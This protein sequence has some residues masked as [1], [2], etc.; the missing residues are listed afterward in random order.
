VTGGDN[1]RHLPLGFELIFACY[2]SF[3][4]VFLEE[5]RPY[6][7]SLH[8]RYLYFWHPHAASLG[9]T[10]FEL[11]YAGLFLIPAF[12][13]F[14]CLRLTRRFPVTRLLLP[15][16]GLVAVAGFPLACMYSIGH[17]FFAIVELAVAATCFLLWMYRKW[18][19]SVPLNG[20]LL[21][22]HNAFWFLFSGAPARI[23]PRVGPWEWGS[24]PAYMGFVCPALS[25]FF[26]LA[27]AVFFRRAE[28]T[29]PA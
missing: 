11:F 14:I 10:D 4:L 3:L 27:W 25:L 23:P 17:P 22:V 12:A 18:P 1:T 16:G 13:I 19:V 24:V 29:N 20:F 9:N 21:I 15:L 8:R 7:W 2:L 26:S 5:W 28:A 6:S